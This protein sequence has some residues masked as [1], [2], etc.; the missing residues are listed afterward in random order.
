[1]IKFYKNIQ[2]DPEIR[3]YELLKLKKSLESKYLRGASSLLNKDIKIRV[4]AFL[5]TKSI[6]LFLEKDIIKLRSKISSYLDKHFKVFKKPGE[7]FV[8]PNLGSV[9]VDVPFFK[10]LS[11]FNSRLEEHNAALIVQGSYAD[12]TFINYSDIDL[13]IIGVLSKEVI[14][15]K[16]EIDNFL[17]NLDPLQHHGAFFIHKDSFLNYWQMDLPIDTLKKSLILSKESTLDISI[18]SY[19]T[20]KLS[21]KFW[22]LNFINGFSKMPIDV[23]SGAFFSKYFFSQLMLVPA[24]LLAYRGDYVYKK[25]SFQMTKKLYTDP[26]W[27]CMEIASNI[28][29]Q[30]DQG[31]ISHK[32]STD[33][34]SASDI[35]VEEYNTL[36]DVINVENISFDDLDQSYLLFVKETKQLLHELR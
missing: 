1:M 22:I 14:S 36:P 27:H 4:K 32:Y 7:Q 2:K 6:S 13:V 31:N 30:W 28:R 10:E 18:P 21:A 19:F 17:L 11:E 33:R 3:L 34:K 29:E 25:E 16:R 35:N 24:L 9:E 26:A 8:I 23:N 15:I 20:E 5:L 12:G